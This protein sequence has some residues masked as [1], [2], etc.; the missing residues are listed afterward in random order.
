MSISV[1]SSTA[2]SEP[3]EPRSSTGDRFPQQAGEPITEGRCDNGPISPHSAR[4]FDHQQ[5]PPQRVT[6]ARDLIKDKKAQR[7]GISS[8]STL[9]AMVNGHQQGD[10][11]LSRRK[12]QFY[13]EVFAYREPNVSARNRVHQFS[14][15]TVEVKTNVIVRRVAPIT[16]QALRLTER[17]GQRRVCLPCGSLPTTFAALS[18]TH[19]LDIRHAGSF[20]LSALCGHLRFCLHFDRHRSAIADST[21]DEQAKRRPHPE[22]HG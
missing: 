22:F 15:I 7:R 11:N 18:P 17:S 20:R 21:H 19:L 5:P 4:S 2:S 13:G 8:E 9:M 14:V 16:N 1:N 10:S 12:S 6:S 3:S